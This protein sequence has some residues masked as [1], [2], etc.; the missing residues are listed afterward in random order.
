MIMIAKRIK[1][2][3]SP[4]T[5]PFPREGSLFIKEVLSYLGEQLKPFSPRKTILSLGRK[6]LSCFGEQSCVWRATMF[7]M[8]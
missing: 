7:P 6:N 3:V 8:E 4:K 5:K 2:Y 1:T